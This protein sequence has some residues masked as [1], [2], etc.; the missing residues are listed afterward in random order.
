M[1]ASIGT[2]TYGLLN[3]LV[4]N[5]AQS[6]QHLNQLAGEVSSGLVAQTYDGLGASAAVPLNVNPQIADL[7]TWQ[8]NISAASG[9]QQTTQAAMTQI[10][11]IAQGFYA[12]MPNLSSLD[13]SEID[14]IAT[15][16]QSALQQVAGLLDTKDGDTYV[17]AG[18]DTANPPVPNPNGILSSGFYTQI[19][20][21]IGNLGTAGG[22]T[23]AAATLSIAASNAAGTS[24]FS[25][26]L[27]QPAATLLAQAP[28][29]QTGVGE[30]QP[31][32]LLASANSDSV[33]TGTS[34]THSYMRDLMRVLATLGSLSSSQA[35]DS[36]FASLVADTTTSLQGAIAA[37]SD[38]AGALGNRQAALTATQTGLAATQTA[39]KTQV[40]AVQ[41][42]DVAKALSEISLVQTQLQASYQLVGGLSGLNLA[43]ILPAA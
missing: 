35:T 28:V 17:F 24:P 29:V 34:T 6:R 18:A 1:S 4:W 36:G 37:M 8:D 16:A 21:A 7:A 26:Y 19:A 3:T 11:Q 43:K 14:S 27:S 40:G 13:T 32:G 10:A 5:S 15:D 30:T 41:D 25:A 31:V 42:A 9:I 38:D 33:S 20:A 23:T 2:G 12:R 39:L 22:P